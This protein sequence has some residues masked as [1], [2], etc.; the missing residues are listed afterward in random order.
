MCSDLTSGNFLRANDR[1]LMDAWDAEGL[2]TSTLQIL[3]YCR[4]YLKVHRLSEIVTNDW[5]HIQEHY[6]SGRNINRIIIHDWPRQ[7][8]PGCKAWKLWRH[9][10]VKTFYSGSRLKIPLGKWLQKSSAY[11]TVYLPELNLIQKY[12]KDGIFTSPVVKTRTTITRS[13]TWHPQ[14]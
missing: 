13:C 6:L 4:I 14:K 8:K 3:N 10:L 7:E 11:D 2:P 5:F 12:T 1:Y 9:H